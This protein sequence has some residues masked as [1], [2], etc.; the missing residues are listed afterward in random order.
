MT[1][2]VD[3]YLQVWRDKLSTELDKELTPADLCSL[4]RLEVN[5]YFFMTK[6]I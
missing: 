2:L 5:K 1:D 3:S 4:F 6:F